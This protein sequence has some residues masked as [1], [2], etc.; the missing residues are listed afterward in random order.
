MEWLKL[1][2]RKKKWFT[3]N[4]LSLNV[5]KTFNGNDNHDDDNHDILELPWLISVFTCTG[6]VMLFSI[7][8]QILLKA[9]YSLSKRVLQFVYQHSR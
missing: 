9:G 8:S 5:G 3:N 1:N 7:L 2:L 6:L 4:R